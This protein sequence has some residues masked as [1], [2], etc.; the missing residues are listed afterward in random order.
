[1]KSEKE[2]SHIPVR[3]EQVPTGIFPK[4]GPQGEEK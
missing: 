1:M 4:E 2:H 3:C